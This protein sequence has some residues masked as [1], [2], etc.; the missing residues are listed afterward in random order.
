MKAGD[1]INSII[2]RVVL[3][4]MTAFLVFTNLNANIS[5]VILL[6]GVVLTFVSE[7]FNSKK[8]IGLLFASVC[9]VS[10]FAESIILIIPLLIYDIFDDKIN[11]I[12]L[13]FLI[14]PLFSSVTNK[15]LF[16][17]VLCLLVALISVLLKVRTTKTEALRSE[18][19]KQR[20]TFSEAVLEQQYAID[21]LINEQDNE[22]RVAVLDERNRIAREIHDNVGHLLSSSILQLGA[23]MTVTRDEQTK[24]FLKTLNDTLSDGMNSIRN[25]VHNL[26]NESIDLKEQ[27]DKIIDNFVF[28]EVDFHY[29]VSQN[30]QANCKYAVI[31]IIKEC[32]TNTAKHSDA[33]KVEIS[34]FEHPKLLQI[35]VSDNGSELTKTAI[36]NGMGL[37]NIRQRV[38]V[39]KGSFNIDTT[40]GFRVFVTFPINNDD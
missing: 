28:C 9:F 10:V 22:V 35:I 5:I 26:R 3:L 32:L 31:G 14:F 20:E 38:K 8:L 29:D 37:E 21:S 12:I 15:M 39:L 2:D 23:L 16:Q 34:V 40:V 6:I 7:Y 11:P 36:S 17:V 24:S 30:L 1:L 33:T 4:I 18:Y 13:A 19:V 27:L 25:S